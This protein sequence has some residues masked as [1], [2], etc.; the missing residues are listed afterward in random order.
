MDKRREHKWL[1]TSLS[2]SFAL[3]LTYIFFQITDLSEPDTLTDKSI[4]ILIFIAAMM[5]VPFFNKIKIFDLEL[6]NKVDSIDKNIKDFKTEVRTNL[7]L[8]SN[9]I[10]TIGNNISNTIS[11]SIPG[12][13]QLRN[14]RIN[15]DNTL[16]TNIKS[17]SNTI[18]EELDINDDGED[19][20]NIMALARTRI[21]LEGLLRII[22]GKRTK[23][24]N[25]TKNIKYLSYSS[26]YCMF[27]DDYSQYKYLQNSFAYVGQIANAAI[28]AQKISY[29]QAKEALDLGSK[30]I[31]IL[32]DIA[33]SNK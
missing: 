19:D 1:L 6:E 3:F 31:A 29:G 2:W 14:E 13:E 23:T 5:L 9:N 8:I 18:K 20:K 10:T 32:E 17:N 33:Q 24:N 16:N 30:L 4:I 7:S 22:I 28:H 21:R 11:I 12:T 15:I 27:I 26:L 25:V